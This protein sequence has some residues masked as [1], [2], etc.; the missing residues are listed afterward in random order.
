MQVPALTSKRAFP[1]VRLKILAAV[2]FLVISSLPALAGADASG[3]VAMADKF[4]SEG[5]YATAAALL[6]KAGEA[7]PG[8]ADVDIA[9]AGLLRDAGYRFLENDFFASSRESFRRALSKDPEHF[10]ALKRLGILLYEGGEFQEA[11]EIFKPLSERTEAEKDPLV[12]IYLRVSRWYQQ[13]EEKGEDAL[14]KDSATSRCDLCWGPL[15]ETHWAL[16]DGRVL[17]GSCFTDAVNDETVAQKLVTEVTASLDAAMGIKLRHPPAAHLVS[18]E[19][20]TRLASENLQSFEEV[21]SGDLAGLYA[22]GENGPVI[23]LLRGMPHF[24]T[25]ETIAHELTHVW[26]GE[27]C[28]PETALGSKEGFSEYVAYRTL[29]ALGHKEAAARMFL[30]RGPYGIHFKRLEVLGRINGDRKVAELMREGL[31]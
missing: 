18:K 12:K 11:V 20:M 16:E 1:P 3:L 7:D 24:T 9:M 2:L 30:S 21:S 23:Y 6:M 14:R 10:L 27:N 15:E 19:E 29:L 26:E 31:Q 8:L 13:V 28:P 17:C 5:K 22:P 4:S 25:L